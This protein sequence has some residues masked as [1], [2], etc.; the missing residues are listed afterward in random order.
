MRA[1]T[2]LGAVLVAIFIGGII[3]AP[4]AA[5]A[6]PNDACLFLTQAQVSAAL[7][8]S[9]AAGTHVS[10]TI[11]KTC[12]WEPSEGATKDVKDITFTL[13][14]AEEYEVGKKTIEQIAATMKAENDEDSPAPVITPAS[15]IGDDAYYLEIANTMSLLV[16]KGRAAF[17]I[18]IYGRLSTAKRQS[19]EKTLALQ[20]LSKM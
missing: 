8:I 7:G 17:K 19:A 20:V 9:M 6:P 4:A 18:V 1:K 16:K 5:A 11:L 14:T 10:S 15:G 3:T 12:T 13:Q 2:R